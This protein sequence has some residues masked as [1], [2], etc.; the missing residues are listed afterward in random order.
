VGDRFQVDSVTFTV[1]HPD[2]TW[3]EWGGDLNEDSIVLLVEYRDF[4]ALFTGDAGE[5]A[6]PLLTARSGP[7]DLLKVGH[8]GS[9]TATSDPFLAQISPR[10]A[11]ISVGSN[12]Y[13]HPSAAAIGRL[14]SRGIPI[15]RT[16]QD[17]EVIVTTDGAIMSVCASRGCSR[18]AVGP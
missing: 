7:V 15:W 12:T 4:T 17:G 1:L 16:D 5:R 2:T 3:S 8:H 14:Q 13:G 11:I 10:A 9:R 18:Q 6:E